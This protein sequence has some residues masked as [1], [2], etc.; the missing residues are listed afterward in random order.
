MGGGGSA[1]LHTAGRSSAFAGWLSSQFVGR[2]D[3]DSRLEALVARLND[4]MK[5]TSS[6]AAGAAALAMAAKIASERSSKESTIL[7]GAAGGLAE[8]VR[9]S[10]LHPGLVFLLN[11]PPQVENKKYANIVI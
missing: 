2:A 1:G 4:E 11:L 9:R 3:M 8:E 5:A 10:E 6:D 7:L